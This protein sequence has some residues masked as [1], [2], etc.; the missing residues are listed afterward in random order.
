MGTTTLHAYPYPDP[1]DPVGDGAAAMAAL[2]NALDKNTQ[3]DVWTP[4]TFVVGTPKTQAV[5]FA[6]AFTAP[7]AVAVSG[8]AFGGNASAWA[9]N[10]TASGFTLN[11]QRAVG[12][13]SFDVHWIATGRTQ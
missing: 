2:A 4:G 11:A 3:A 12:T 13:A 8:E 7:P 9:T 1:G 6:E 10:V 5:T